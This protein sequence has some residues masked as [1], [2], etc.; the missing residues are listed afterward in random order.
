MSLALGEGL[1]SGEEA[2]VLDMTGTSDGPIPPTIPD[3]MT[4]FETAHEFIHRAFVG[5]TEKLSHIME[6]IEGDET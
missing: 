6:L 3:T 5:T 1:V 2:V 4:V